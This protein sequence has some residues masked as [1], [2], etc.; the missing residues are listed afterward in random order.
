MSPF[1]EHS[2]TWV[3]A[4]R[5]HVSFPRLLETAL[6]QPEHSASLSS[7]YKPYPIAHPVLARNQIYSIILPLVYGRLITMYMSLHSKSYHHPRHAWRPGCAPM[8]RLYLRDVHLGRLASGAAKRA[9]VGRGGSWPTAATWR[10]RQDGQETAVLR[11]W[12]LKRDPSKWR[13]CLRRGVRE[14]GWKGA[15][16]TRHT[17][18][19]R[20]LRHHA[21][22]GTRR[23][24]GCAV[25]MWGC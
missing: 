7:S 24:H 19:N 11:T 13:P 4:C 21:G 22:S 10:Q 14:G 16:Q 1:I 17:C 18:C 15:R 3:G 12:M 23:R 9:V 2:I 8:P 20:R 25:K 5:V 6:E